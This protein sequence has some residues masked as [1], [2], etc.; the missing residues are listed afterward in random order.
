MPAIVAFCYDR[1]VRLTRA[2]LPCLLA[3]LFLSRGAA[4]QSTTL[5]LDPSTGSLRVLLYKDGPLRALGHDHALAAPAFQGQVELSSGSAQLM[6]TI[7]ATKLVIDTAPV[8]E[9]QG[10]SALKDSD[11]ESINAG[12]RGPR[13]LDV[14]KYPQITFRSDTIEPVA[15]EKDLWEVTGRFSLHGTTQTIDFPVTMTD[16]PGGKWFSGYVRLRQSEY[17]VKP[18]TV[19]GGAVSVKD[20]ILVRFN[21]LGR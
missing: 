10:W 2:L 6:L 19:F 8:R 12:M 9:E 1:P 17:G 4:A 15:G 5:T 16:G 14:K 20:E 3:A 13:G 18:F 7:D 11:V 21:L